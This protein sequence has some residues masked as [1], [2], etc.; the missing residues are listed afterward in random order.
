MGAKKRGVALGARV[1]AEEA[2][3]AESAEGGGGREAPRTW[4][5][6]EEKPAGEARGGGNWAE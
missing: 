2:A 3:C 1:W 5:R 4:S 6:A